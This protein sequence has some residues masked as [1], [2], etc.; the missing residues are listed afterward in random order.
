MIKEIFFNSGNFG[1]NNKMELL[2]YLLTVYYKAALAK[3]VVEHCQI[4]T[5]YNTYEEIL[6]AILYE[7]LES[8]GEREEGKKIIKSLNALVLKF[9]ESFNT[10]FT[11]VALI[12]LIQ[13]Y[14]SD[15]SRIC[16]LS[17]KCLLKLSNIMPSII[18]HLEIEKI[19]IAIFEFIYEFE[20]THVDLTTTS[21]NEEMCLKILRTIIHEIIKIKNEGIW[22]YYR[23]A[24]ER[25]NLPDKFL[26]RWIQL[27]MRSKNGI[28]LPS[29]NSGGGY[30]SSPIVNNANVKSTFSSN[31]LNYSGNQ[32]T[33]QSISSYNPNI[34]LSNTTHTGYEYDNDLNFYLEKLKKELTHITND[35]R[36]SANEKIYCELIAIIKRNNIPIE[37]LKDKMN[38]HHYI[39]LTRIFTT[40]T[41]EE[42]SQSYSSSLNLNKNSEKMNNNL[43]VHDNKAEEKI[44]DFTMTSDR[45]KVG[46]RLI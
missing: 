34:L 20:K 4:E 16:S 5:V 25:N 2:K 18:A 35:S 14:C 33:N 12:K 27:I 26:K 44:S 36:G 17:I 13:F 23:A 43:T 40:V 41:N 30:N 15:N 31:I 42:G 9:M 7:G 19:L 45:E 46:I 3:D 22:N 1:W 8:I 21:Q 39:T 29:S 38:E 24:I 6:R 11:F 10:T 32:H 28:S 37:F